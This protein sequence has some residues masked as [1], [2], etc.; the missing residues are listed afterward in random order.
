MTPEKPGDILSGHGMWKTRANARLGIS[1]WWWQTTPT[2]YVTPS[3][4]SNRMK[5]AA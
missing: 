5:R 1:I 3:N 4:R 2:E